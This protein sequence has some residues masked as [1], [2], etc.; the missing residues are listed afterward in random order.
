MDTAK[1]HRMQSEAAFFNNFSSSTLF[2]FRFFIYFHFHFR[3]EVCLADDDV[4]SSGDCEETKKRAALSASKG[5]KA[6][7]NRSKIF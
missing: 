4:A 7:N 6:A 2:S 5:G 3:S 1:L